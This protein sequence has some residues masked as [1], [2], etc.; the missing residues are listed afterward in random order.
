MDQSEANRLI[1]VKKYF[2]DKNI[3]LPRANECRDLKVHSED[4]KDEFRVYLNRKGRID[5]LRCTYLMNCVTYEPLVRVDLDLHKTHKNPD[6]KV[7]KGPHVHIY[8]EEFGD[9][10]A[11][12][13]EDIFPGLDPR[14]LEE[15]FRR[16]CDYCNL[17]GF[18]LQD[19]WDV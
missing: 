12:P 9:K 8:N 3:I 5:L 15:A 18:L 6:D 4:D 13:L 7:I 1:Q 10:I 2:V 14:N 17:I 11:Y 19:R 16:F